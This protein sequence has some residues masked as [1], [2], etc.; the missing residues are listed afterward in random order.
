MANPIRVGLKNL[1]CINTVFCGEQIEAVWGNAVRDLGQS[2]FERGDNV[3][4]LFSAID[5]NLVTPIIGNTWNMIHAYSNNTSRLIKWKYE[6][7]YIRF[8]PAFPRYNH[9]SNLYAGNTP[10]GS[11]YGSPIV[12]N[13]ISGK[14]YKIAQFEN[15]GYTHAQI[16]ATVRRGQRHDIDNTEITG[17]TYIDIREFKEDSAYTMAYRQ[18]IECWYMQENPSGSMFPPIKTLIFNDS[19]CPIWTITDIQKEIVLPITPI[20][21]ET[22]KDWIIVSVW[23][24]VLY[25]P[26]VTTEPYYNNDTLWVCNTGYQ[27]FDMNSDGLYG[28]NCKLFKT[29]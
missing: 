26:I 24:E 29:C 15:A 25:S 2:S 17:N 3:V 16:F 27:D 8:Q 6:T 9:C 18:H 11:L 22:T 4:S 13:G 21:G 12:D 1:H 5:G 10:N 20:V 19:D 28:L 14:Q 23:N 7:D